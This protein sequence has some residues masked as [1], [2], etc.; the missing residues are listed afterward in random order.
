MKFARVSIA[1]LVIQIVFVS[2]VALK[3][4][5]QRATCPRVW[6]RAAAY[7]LRWSCADAT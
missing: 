6:T 7:I 4:L 1:L 5:Y 2:S 3:Y